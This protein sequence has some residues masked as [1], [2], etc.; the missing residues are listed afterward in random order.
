MVSLQV[1]PLWGWMSR[2]AYYVCGMHG[3]VGFY[4]GI[5]ILTPDLVQ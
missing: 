1:A 2:P 4:L 5:V 3:L